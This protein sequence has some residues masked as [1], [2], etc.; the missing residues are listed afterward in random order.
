[1]AMHFKIP[2]DNISNKLLLL[3]LIKI[4]RR[5]YSPCSQVMLMI[6][7]FSTLVI[8]INKAEVHF[9]G[10]DSSTCR[11]IGGDIAVRLCAKFAIRMA[12][13]NKINMILIRLVAACITIFKLLI[14]YKHI[15]KLHLD[16]KYLCFV[17]NSIR[18]LCILF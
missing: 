2:I 18:F 8:G 5:R 14:K 17:L 6:R 12:H 3:L 1:M 7:L 13:K 15:L 4:E 10:V 16:D 11:S 9:I